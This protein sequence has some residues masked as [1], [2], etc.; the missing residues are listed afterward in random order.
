MNIKSG[1][2]KS[3]QPVKDS[4]LLLLDEPDRH[5]PTAQADMLASMTQPLFKAG[6]LRRW[7]WRISG[8]GPHY[9]MSGRR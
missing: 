2:A 3:G 9:W 5:V 4:R 6:R 7:W 8:R 1:Q